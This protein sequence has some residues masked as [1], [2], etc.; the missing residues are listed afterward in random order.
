[1]ACATEVAFLRAIL[2]LTVNSVLRSTR[3][4]KALL[5]SFP[6]SVSHSQSPIRRLL[7]MIADRCEILTLLGI[8]LDVAPEA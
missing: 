6:V 2:A 3:V 4:T 8:K 1:M 5:R 7:S